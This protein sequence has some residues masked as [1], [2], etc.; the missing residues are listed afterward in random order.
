MKNIFYLLLS[1]IFI[2]ASC[3]NGG[4]KQTASTGE[5]AV[6]TD[7]S[8]S[9]AN[10]KRYLIKSGS[11]VYKGPMG[12]IQTLYFDDFGASE[13]FTTE[14]DMGIAK[15]KETQIRKD[16]FQYSF[17]EGDSTGRKTKWYAPAADYTKMDAEALKKYKMKDLGKETISGK[18]CTK[19]SIEYG[20]STMYSWMWN[21]IM[22]KSVTKMGNGEMIIEATK[23]EESPIDAN[24]FR[25]PDNITFEEV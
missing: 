7:Q 12:V 23:I 14:L 6:S 22:V 11:V 15:S 20:G 25:L 16:G 10:V 21:N 18:E 13:V 1:G 17:K 24:L 3:K 5:N 19:Y 4:E 9:E 8:S 2:L